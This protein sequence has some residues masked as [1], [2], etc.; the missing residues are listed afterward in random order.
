MQKTGE[1]SFKIVIVNGCY[2]VWLPSGVWRC[3]TAEKKYSF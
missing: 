2:G 3:S 1:L